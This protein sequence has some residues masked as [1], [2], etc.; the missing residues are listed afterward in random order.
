MR[1]TLFL[2]FVFTFTVA[3]A[4]LPKDLS[5]TA[6]TIDTTRVWG[7]TSDATNGVNNQVNALSHM[8]KKPT[9]RIVFDEWQPVTEYTS[10]VSSIHNVSFIMGEL[11][12]S[13]YMIQYNLQQYTDRMNEYMNGVG[14]KVDIW[15]VGNEVNGEWCGKTTDV[16]AKISAAYSIVKAYGKKT[17]LTLYEN[18]NCW[19]KSS[20]EMFRWVNQNIPANMKQGLDYV[21]VSYYEDDCNGYQPNWQ[22]VFDSLH[23]IFPNSKLGIGEC[24]TSRSSKKASYMTRYY[25]M[26]IT[27]PNFVGGYFWWYWRQD[28]VPYTKKTLWT[29][30]DK[31]IASC[32]GSDQPLS[33]NPTFRLS[34]YPNPFNP[35]TKIS[36]YLPD[37]GNITLKIYDLLGKE[38]A[39]LVDDNLNA[40]NYSVEWNAANYSS[41]I[42]LYKLKSANYTETKKMLLV[43]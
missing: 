17:A 14:D 26:H 37:A 30:M 43:K 1:K 18:W 6:Q 8:C 27:T 16:V 24:G 31:A 23:V 20:N 4:E 32:Y 29:T 21:W 33:E 36:F 12:D 5:I 11:L 3:A 38:V 10:F 9:I 19:E 40:G 7:V 34:N 35:A 15:E 42:Y 28:C 2:L 25:T 13:E 39:T 22:K 41:G